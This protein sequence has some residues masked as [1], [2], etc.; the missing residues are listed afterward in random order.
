[1][2]SANADAAEFWADMAPT[3]L[4]L[5][6]QLEEVGGPPGQWAMERLSI[7]PGDRVLDVGCG[8]GR[9]TVALARRVAPG[10][11]AV[12]IDIAAEMLRRG[13]DHAA[14]QSIDNVEFV[15]ADAQV[16]VLGN[17][18][19]DA[20]YS[21]FGVMF[22]A[23][24][25]AAFA[26]I[27]RSLRPGGRL[28]FACWQDVFANEWMLIPGTAAVSAT[29]ITPPM[30]GPD[31]PGPFAF[32][33]ATRVRSILDQAGFLAIEVVPRNDV[34]VTDE[35]RIPEIAR[36]STRVGMVRELLRDSD[37]DTRRRVHEAIEDAMRSR[38]EEGQV[39]ASRGVHLVTA[40]A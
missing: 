34:V 33:D 1:M 32:A 8:T 28:S 9:T 5:E 18:I 15:H 29:G 7:E 4:E 26:N 27:R 10:G 30:P 12:G 36:V 22:F 37:E 13:R 38:V 16:H 17:A 25:V 14:A 19:F 21:R 40:H 23:D 2:A 35:A 3:W 20:A 31:E 24:P 39:R 6:D 11:R